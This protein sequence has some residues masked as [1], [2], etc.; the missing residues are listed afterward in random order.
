MERFVV[1]KNPRHKRGGKNPFYVAESGGSGKVVAGPYK[2]RANAKAVA[3]MRGGVRV[4]FSKRT[5][6]KGKT[7]TT[8]ARAAKAAAASSRKSAAAAAAAA[9]KASVAAAAV[10]RGHSEPEQAPSQYAEN[11]GRRR[12][13]LP[14]GFRVPRLPEESPWYVL[15]GKKSKLPVRHRR[16]RIRKVF[17]KRGR[18]A[19]RGFSA[20]AGGKH[21]ASQKQMVYRRFFAEKRRQGMS[22]KAVGAAWRRSHGTSKRN[23][24]KRR[25]VRRNTEHFPFTGD[26]YRPAI[27]MKGPKAGFKRAFGRIKSKYSSYLAK[28][29]YKGS[30]KD[31]TKILLKGMRKKR[32]KGGKA[33]SNAMVRWY[34]KA[35]KN[36]RRVSR[37]PF[38]FKIP[39]VGGV[40]GKLKEIVSLKT[41]KE[42]LAVLAGAVIASGA[43]SLLPSSWNT[44]YWGLGLSI[45]A[46]GLGAVAVAMFAPQFLVPI[47]A[48][49]LV[50]VGLRL[51]GTF[52]PRAMNWGSPSA[53]AP[54]T[55]AGYLNYSPGMS[56]FLQSSR[57][58]GFLAPRLQGL[59]GSAEGFKVRKV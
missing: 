28:K 3:S 49:G 24:P 13:V 37:N 50:A 53:L 8:A 36:R 38:G 52:A 15:K 18:K 30:K 39:S 10:E 7:M 47:A 25:H 27:H 32:R 48:G 56:G 55:K 23:A 42:G 54:A 9:K 4:V 19:R 33:R 16:A 58:G 41:I 2:K 20:R 29:R 43:P 40:I 51:V 11:R 57:V 44:G 26:L 59:S 22:A 35:R 21:M 17:V 45:L 1:L 46:A 5:Y 6:K 14:R 31:F 12:V 34:G